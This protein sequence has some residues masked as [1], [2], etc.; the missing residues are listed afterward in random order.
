MKE[1]TLTF[2][3]ICQVAHQ[4]QQ[5]SRHGR[6]DDEDLSLLLNSLIQMSPDNTLAVYGGN[7][8]NLKQG[9]ELLVSHLGDTSNSTKEKD[10]EF[11]R[12]VISLINLER[13]LTKQ[14]KQMALLGDRLEA[15]KRQLEHY[16]ITSETLVASFASIYS[17]II[18][19]LGARIQVTGEPSILK[20][21]ANQHKI[22]ALLLSGIRAA[23]LWRQVGGK[24]RAILF[25]R[26]KIVNSAK[27]LLKTI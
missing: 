7:L 22:R 19:P 12:Y 24:R 15:S 26:K 16:A 23:V 21:T 9:L 14:S 6:I 13:R 17:D 10:P 2:A 5:V 3:A 8:T 11:T 4:V 27:Q 20:Q 25:S 18:S 1:I